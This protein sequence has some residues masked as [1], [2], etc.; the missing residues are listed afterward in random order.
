[1]FVMQIQFFQNTPANIK[2]RAK[3]LSGGRAKPIR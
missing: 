3:D 2:E 1:M